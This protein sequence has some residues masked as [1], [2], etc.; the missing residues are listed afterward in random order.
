[1]DGPP[2]ASLSLTHVHYVGYKTWIYH[3][4]A[5]RCR[6]PQTAFHTYAHGLLSFRRDYASSMRRSS[7][8]TVKLRYF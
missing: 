3:V 1:M 2:L 7:G 4:L 5:N 6:I 8:Q